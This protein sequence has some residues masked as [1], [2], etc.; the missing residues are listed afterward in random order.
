MS[1]SIDELLEQHAPAIA[2]L[3]EALSTE[4]PARW[5]DIFLLRYVLS[6]AE[7]ERAA[8]VRKALAWRV[9]HAPMLAGAAAGAPPPHHALLAPY[10][11]ADFHGTTKHGDSLYIVRTGLSDIPAMLGGG[12]TAEMIVDYNMANREVAFIMADRE[13]RARRTLVKTITLVDLRSEVSSF[14][15]T[16]MKAIGDSSK[17]AEFLYPQLLKRT[18]LYN[19]PSFFGIVFS[20]IKPVMSAKSLEKTTVCPGG[21]AQPRGPRAAAACPFAAALFDVDSLP[22]FLGGACRCSAKGGCVG[23]RPNEQ[24]RPS[25]PGGPR[26]ALVTVGARGAHDVCL[27]ARAA[28][29]VLTYSFE[30][31]SGGLEVGATLLPADGGAPVVL[32]P[33]AKHKAG[34]GPA[35]GAVAVPTPGT[36]VLRFSNAH[37]LLTSK[38][39]TVT[40]RVDAAAAAGGAEGGPA[41]EA[42]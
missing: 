34:G 16:F 6:F 8:T 2:T 38:S 18:V 28:G 22:T 21:G 15:S 40:A 17:L 29:D 33:P 11:C 39:V 20:L 7:H 31:A 37:S 12:V 14:N 23:G 30:L 3:R 4:L 25:P 35:T 27:G 24:L 41:K 36:V 19:P 10:Q 32:V 13:T 9:A 1:T 42:S 26:G 5:D